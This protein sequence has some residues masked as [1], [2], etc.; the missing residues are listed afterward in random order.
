[1]NDEDGKFKELRMPTL[2][3]IPCHPQSLLRGVPLSIEWLGHSSFGGRVLLKMCT[4]FDE[5]AGGIASMALTE[6]IIQDGEYIR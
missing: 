1:M 4:V 6:V 5:L 2:R 3:Q